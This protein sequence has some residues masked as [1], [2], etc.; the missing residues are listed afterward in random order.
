MEGGGDVVS[1]S[2]YQVNGGGGLGEK[3]K[4]N[5]GMEIVAVASLVV[6]MYKDNKLLMHWTPSLRSRYLGT[7]HLELH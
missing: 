2:I 1:Y 4:H 6:N 7:S 5:S 3:N